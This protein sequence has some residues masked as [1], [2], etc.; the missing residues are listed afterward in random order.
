M[1]NLVFGTLSA[2]VF[3]GTVIP[4]RV[5]AAQAQMTAS[6]RASAPFIVDSGLAGATGDRHFI[7]V[8][9]TGFPLEELT[10]TLPDDMRILEAAKVTNQMGKEVE[11]NVA[12]SK[13]MVTLNF[14]KPVTPNELLK[15]TLSG[16]R[17][18]RQGG[19]ALYRVSAINAGLVGVIPIGAAMVRLQ[20]HGG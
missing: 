5:P 20:D 3:A 8:A 2:L 4:T 11:A 7:T 18:D 6:V 14:P 16:V 12:I 15:V 10:I 9:V 19:S 1:R 17:M 13:G